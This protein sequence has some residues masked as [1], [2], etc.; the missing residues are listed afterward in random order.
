[1]TKPYWLEGEKLRR[2]CVIVDGDDAWDF[3]CA[4]ADGDNARVRSMLERD[5]NF[6]HAQLWYSKPIDQALRHGHLDVV[7][8]IHEFD[9]ENR[10]A[11]YIADGHTYRCDKRELQRRGHTKILK[12]LDEE[13]WPRLVPHH[14]PELDELAKLFPGE[15]DKDQSVDRE[16]VINAMKANPALLAGTDRMGRSILHLAIGSKKLELAKELVSLGAAIDRKMADNQLVTDLAAY[17]LPET[18]PWLL[19][20]GLEPSF[21]TSVAAG[22][23]EIVRAMVK[24]DPA[25][26]NRVNADESSPLHLA[27]SNRQRD[28]VELLL[29]LGADPNYPEQ[30]SPS[31]AALAVAAERNEVEI[32]RLLLKAGANPN[33]N[34]DSS[35]T[36][37]MFCTHW[38]RRHPKEAIELL[39]KY[40]ARPEGESDRNG[41]S[42]LEFLESAPTEEILA[43]REDGT[44]L[45]RVR[46]PEELD[47][48]VERVGNE[49]ILKGP[50]YEMCK[51]PSSV[52]LLK[53]AVHHGLDVNKGDWLGRTQLHA[54]AASNEH[55]W[56]ECLLEL[57][58]DINAIDTHSSTTPLGFAARCG[59][60]EMVKFLL[61]RGANPRLPAEDG[62]A[63]AQPIAY[64]QAY[65][66]DHDYRYRLEASNQGELTGRFT[67]STRKQYEEVIALLSEL[68]DG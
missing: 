8:T 30:D 18:L 29:E 63:W 5:R 51:C 43:V 60:A 49:R 40:G 28:M 16:K 36:V 14:M 53:R 27:A 11:F 25:I 24:E 2:E 62:F 6:M 52:D 15:W 22:L 26:V 20:L 44:R 55:E 39:L 4:C 34:I 38:G 7:R 21:H 42:L 67:M 13:Y 19:D 31:G 3:V 45:S 61:D 64:A 54:A 1:M 35:G 57:G 58:A 46:T 12:Y 66:E 37:Y 65:W 32:M 59:H 48:Y 23:A 68:S 17:R 47:A 9:Q 50:W 56:A 33:A 10:L 41:L